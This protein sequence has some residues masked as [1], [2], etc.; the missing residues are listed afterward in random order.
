[1]S[2]L[3]ADPYL[4]YVAAAYGATFLVVGLLIAVSLRANA[5]ARH[6]LAEAEKEARRH[7]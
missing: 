3:L 6:E 7:G 5:R 4:V 2:A 1:M